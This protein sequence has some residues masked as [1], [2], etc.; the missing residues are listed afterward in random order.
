MPEEPGRPAFG[1]GG[2]EAEVPSPQCPYSQLDAQ[3]SACA[4]VEPTA[5]TS[6]GASAP[7]PQALAPALAQAPAGSGAPPEAQAAPPLGG[8]TADPVPIPP[9]PGASEAVSV[10]QWAATEKEAAAHSSAARHQHI[11]REHIPTTPTPPVLAASGSPVVLPEEWTPSSAAA[12]GVAS[13]AD[14]A[15]PLLGLNTHPSCRGDNGTSSTEDGL[16]ATAWE[17]AAAHSPALP[18]ST[19]ADA[20][21]DVPLQ[22][23]DGRPDDDAELQARGEFIEQQQQ[24]VAAAALPHEQALLEAE[25]AEHR[26]L[27]MGAAGGTRR[28][29]LADVAAALSGAQQDWHALGRPDASGA[30]IG[31][32]ALAKCEGLPVCLPAGVGDQLQQR[33]R[34]LG[35]PIA[36]AVS[37][38]LVALGT[39]AG[40]TVVAKLQPA[41]AAA[42]APAAASS[43]TP[44]GGDAAPGGGAPGM[45]LQLGEPASQVE[46]I[47]ALGFSVTSAPGDPL[48]L[49]AGHANGTVVV[50]DIQRRPAKQVATI[51]E[52]TR[53]TRLMS[54]ATVIYSAANITLL[55]P[56]PSRLPRPS[57]LSAAARLLHSYPS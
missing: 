1:E 14:R 19:P 26:L 51:G 11:S 38:P 28:E 23:D 39:A 32:R 25:A 10:S 49:V 8:L 12:A 33:W 13:P 16:V 46:A 44:S 9:H 36:I 42:A 53:W 20:A 30:M 57:S 24:P 29:P 34:Q 4:S 45:V 50:W 40:V 31:G 21:A 5:A 6:G 41:A 2:A 47:T 22:V 3:T 27:T 56:C 7:P 17:G 48:W 35:Q 55:M 54:Q 18:R 37:G 15:T 43:D 52:S